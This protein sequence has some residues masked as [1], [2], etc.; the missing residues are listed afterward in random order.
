MLGQL[1]VLE[2]HDV[3]VGARRGDCVPDELQSVLLILG[4]KHDLEDANVVGLSELGVGQSG[5]KLIASLE[6][7][8]APVVQSQHRNPVTF[9]HRTRDS[10]SRRARAI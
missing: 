2:K 8:R 6:I 10:R 4:I 3:V 7:S 9:R 5:R 1:W